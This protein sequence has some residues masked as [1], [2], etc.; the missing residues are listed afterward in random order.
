[1]PFKKG[2]SG[3]PS[4]RPKGAANKAT[5]ELRSLVAAVIRENWTTFTK[6]IKQLDPD[7]RVAIIDRLLRHVLPAPQDPIN[8]LTVEEIEAVI[9]HLKNRYS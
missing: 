6:D 4:G 3:N 9:T 8:S 1:M 2:T 7:K 5:D